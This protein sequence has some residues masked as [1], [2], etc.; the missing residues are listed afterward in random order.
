[1]KSI[2]MR[3]IAAVAA[4]CVG[5]L[6]IA[7]ASAGAGAG[8]DVDLAPGLAP[9]SASV[10]PIATTA[11]AQSVVDAYP[12]G[13]M[14]SIATGMHSNWSVDPKTG[15][16]FIG[17]AGAILNGENKTAQAFTA[18]GSPNNVTIDG[19]SATSR[20]LVEN[21]TDNGINNGNLEATV[22]PGTTSATSGWVIEFLEV[23]Y[24][25]VVGIGL[26]SD[27]ET[28][29]E[30]YVHDNGQLG[31]GGGGIGIV[32]EGNLVTHNGYHLVTRYSVEAGGI[33]VESGAAY[34]PVSEQN[35]TALVVGNTIS[36]NAG[37]PGFHTD[38]HSDGVWF[39][40]N[41]VSGN[42]QIGVHF[43][44]SNYQAVDD[45]VITG[46]VA[47]G[48]EVSAS[49]YVT[50]TGN[51]VTN[52]GGGIVLGGFSRSQDNCKLK[53]PNTG[54]SHFMASDNTVTNSGETGGAQATKSTVASF[55]GDKYSGANYW[56][57]EGQQ[58][59]SFAQW[60]KFFPSD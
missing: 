59:L 49:W 54:T 47:P 6:G 15:D 23:A 2:L 55:T 24:N 44:T 22:D 9:A 35:A 40:Y 52:N 39:V 53:S 12:P 41:I 51:S 4:V 48:I 57:W 29:K 30:N 50:A 19:A 32:V 16:T 33:K 14:F 18:A 31:M 17:Q 28:V 60:L 3:R 34:G 36:A 7:T 26:A 5:W 8:S 42:Q 25:S 27:H 43:E 20:M 58:K 45:N 46:N 21:Y 10:V 56:E 13:T 1:M 38:C 11:N 37:G